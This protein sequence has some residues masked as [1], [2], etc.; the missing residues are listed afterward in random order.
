MLIT[1]V[2]PDGRKFRFEEGKAPKGAE[3]LK[4]NKAPAEKAK[5]QPANKAKTSPA[6]KAKKA[7]TK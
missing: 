5:K 4:K 7:A 3:P 1:Y 2:M 6:N